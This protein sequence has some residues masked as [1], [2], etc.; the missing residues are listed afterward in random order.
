MIGRCLETP[1][2][3]NGAP[4]YISLCH[5][6]NLRFERWRRWRGRKNVFFRRARV[7]LTASRAL[8][9]GKHACPSPVSFSFFPFF[10]Y[11]RPRTT[12]SLVSDYPSD[13]AQKSAWN[14]IF[15]VAYSSNPYHLQLIFLDICTCWFLYSF[16]LLKEVSAVY[17]CITR[18]FKN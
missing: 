6:H 15:N 5:F 7:L 3:C 14:V 2:L 11:P 10:S 4:Y 8:R 13:L 1:S 18:S 16:I 12:S 9:G 17:R